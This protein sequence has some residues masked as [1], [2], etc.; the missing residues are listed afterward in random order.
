MGL[1]TEL[2]IDGDKCKSCG[3]LL[4]TEGITLDRHIVIRDGMAITM[5]AMMCCRC[6]AVTEIPYWGELLPTERT[7]E[8]SRKLY[9]V[10]RKAKAH[11][12]RS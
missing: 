4:A 6:F 9:G 7:K 3:S 1:R 12:G 5:V 2:G 8:F 10:P 11:G